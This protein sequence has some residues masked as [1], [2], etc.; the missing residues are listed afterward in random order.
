[1]V[2]ALAGVALMLLTF[3]FTLVSLLP[4]ATELAPGARASF[5][6][7]ILASFSLSRILG[8]VVGGWLWRW[9]SIA[10]NAAAGAIC[11]LVAAFVLARGIAEEIEG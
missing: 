6:S 10:L 5:F 1:M 3:E 4:L 9:E 11:A 2:A 8:A 7:L